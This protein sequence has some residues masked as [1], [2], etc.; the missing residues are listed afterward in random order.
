MS[1]TDGTEAGILTGPE[2]LRQVAKKR[3]VIDPFTPTRINP[4]SYDLTLGGKVAVYTAVVIPD[5]EPTQSGGVP[6]ERVRIRPEANG[7]PCL[8]FTAIPGRNCLDAAQP[9]EIAVHELD[10]RGFLIRPGIGYLMHTAERVWTDSY[11]PIIDGK[12][13]IGRLFILVHFT[14]GFG[15]PMF[16][17]QYTLEVMATHPVVIYGGQRFAQIR[18]HTTVGE[19]LS[20]EE[21]GN[22]QGSDAMGPVASKSY[23]QLQM[24]GHTAAQ[25]RTR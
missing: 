24:D 25:H 11:V 19:I 14:A 16:K 1:D 15:D 3:I 22:Y 21:A 12:S 13:S 4:G 17:G 9:N 8:P 2:I 18:F 7:D 6:G 5:F 10:E 23:K 20:Y